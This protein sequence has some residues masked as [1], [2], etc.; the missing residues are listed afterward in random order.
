MS[1]GGEPRIE[2]IVK[3]QKKV[4]GGTGRGGGGGQGGFE[5]RIEVTVKMQ[6]TKSGARSGVGS[7]RGSSCWGP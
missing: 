4:G 5:K 1:G 6:K 7:D 2:V 3:M